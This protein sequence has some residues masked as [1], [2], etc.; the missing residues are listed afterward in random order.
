MSD[1]LK[2]LTE[3][4]VDLEKELALVMA[5]ISAEKKKQSKASPSKVMLET[6]KKQTIANDELR[7]ANKKLKKICAI[8]LRSEGNTYK[9]VAESIGVSSATVQKYIYNAE[10]DLQKIECENVKY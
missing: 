4:R 8:V 10:R 7:A 5:D 3:R 9:S 1:E 2:E 6:I